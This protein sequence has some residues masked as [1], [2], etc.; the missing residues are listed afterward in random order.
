MENAPDAQLDFSDEELNRILDEVEQW[1]AR[2]ADTGQYQRLSGYAHLVGASVIL[3]FAEYLYTHVGQAPQEWTPGGVEEVC[4]R[5]MPSKIAAG[6]EFFSAAP[7]V[8]TAFLDYTQEAGLLAQ[9]PA[10]RRGRGQ[11]EHEQGGGHDGPESRCRP[12]R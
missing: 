3:Y 11:L 9:A 7:D 6:P 2:F 5:V 12:G 8:L 4:M 10:L 1:Y